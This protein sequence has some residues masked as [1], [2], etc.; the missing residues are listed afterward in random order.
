MARTINIKTRE[1]FQISLGTLWC[2]LAAGP[3]FGFS[4]LKSILG[5]EGV[6]SKYCS[7][8]DINN[9]VICDKQDY[10]LNNLYVYCVV[11]TYA[12]I[13]FATN[14][15]DSWGSWICGSIGSLS[16]ILGS[17]I[18]CFASSGTES[19]VDL[20]CLGFILFSI[21]GPFIYFSTFQLTALSHQTNIILGLLTGASDASPGLF[22]VYKYAYEHVY[23]YP[24]KNFFG[25]Y[26]IIPVGILLSQFFI[27]PHNRTRYIGNIIKMADQRTITGGTTTTNRRR[28]GQSLAEEDDDDINDNEETTGLLT[29]STDGD[30]D[31]DNNSEDYMEIDFTAAYRPGSGSSNNYAP[32]PGRVNSLNNVIKDPTET[33]G[34]FGV[35]HEMDLSNQLFSL[36]FVFIV[37][38][39]MIQMIIINSFIANNFNQN[40][41]ILDSTLSATRLSR[42]FDVALPLG[43]I[44][45][46]GFISPLLDNLSTFTIFSICTLISAILQ[47]LSLIPWVFIAQLKMTLLALYRPLFYSV[48][49]DYCAKVFGFD[50]FSVL[51]GLVMFVSGV[52][53]LFTIYFDWLTYKVLNHNPIPVNLFLG[54][55]TS[56]VGSLFLIHIW[57][58]SKYIRRKQLEDEARHAPVQNMPGV[59]YNSTNR[60]DEHDP[61][62]CN[63]NGGC[64]NCVCEV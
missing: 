55:L 14:I 62:D 13:I 52:G 61:N 34:V 39:S 23:K 24:L 36:W 2:F 63:N 11:C 16:L 33:S 57:R 26:I 64:E 29:S 49:I 8:E 20:Y 4:S 7:P 38:F 58:Q 1:V 46:I 37:G 18:I 40:Q 45:G 3:I 41:Y 53:N 35:L 60:E 48:I 21:G 9:S 43:G 17:L 12:T 56:A 19:F 30:N 15:I 44:I 59:T 6:Y 50:T 31:N 27:M 22:S 32:R 51:Y 42:F 28:R 47:L 54:V 10:K 5:S 25:V